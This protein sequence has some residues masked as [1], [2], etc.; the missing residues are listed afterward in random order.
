MLVTFIV[1]ALRWLVLYG[2]Y[3]GRQMYRV[4]I[5]SDLGDS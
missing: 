4:L 3:L 5:E 1:M 2:L